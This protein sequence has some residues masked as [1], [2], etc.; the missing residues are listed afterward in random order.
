MVKN[1]RISTEW[2]KKEW[3]IKRL[4]C[5]QKKSETLQIKKKNLAESVQKVR[6]TNRKRK[7]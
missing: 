7:W 6:E 1:E 3:Q 2:K 4:E 5:F